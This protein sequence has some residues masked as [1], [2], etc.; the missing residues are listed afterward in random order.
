LI[1]ATYTKSKKLP[2]IH[3]FF[4]HSPKLAV[5]AQSING[6]PVVAELYAACDIKAILSAS[7]SAAILIM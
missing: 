5:A 6:S 1:I 7:C 3:T 2:H 4:V